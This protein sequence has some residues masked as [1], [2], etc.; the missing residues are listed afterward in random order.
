MESWSG[1]MEWSFGVDFGVEWSQIL[2]FFRTG[3]Y[4]KQR[5]SDGVGWGQILEGTSRLKLRQ[6]QIIF[7]DLPKMSKFIQ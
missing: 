4:H 3:F 7:Y 2:S 6:S 5:D 1:A